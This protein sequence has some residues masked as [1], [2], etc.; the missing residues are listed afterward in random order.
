MPGTEKDTRV[1]GSNG[2]EGRPDRIRF[3]G[4]V[5]VVSSVVIFL[6]AALM[7]AVWSSCRRR[8]GSY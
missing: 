2:E 4:A 8:G 6:I 7:N 5:G 3:W 1:S